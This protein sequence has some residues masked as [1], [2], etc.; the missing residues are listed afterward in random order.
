MPAFAEKTNVC[1]ASTRCTCVYVCIYKTF[2]R[3]QTFITFLVVL[4]QGVK[5]SS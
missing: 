1:R 5:D 2:V 4:L 3:M